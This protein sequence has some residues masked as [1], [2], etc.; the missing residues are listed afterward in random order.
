MNVCTLKQAKVHPFNFARAGT[1][2]AA[3][4]TDVGIQGKLTS[5]AACV[6][7]LVLVPVYGCGDTWP[8]V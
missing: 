1:F 4:A 6:V 5:M 8:E 2:G 3:P 7:E